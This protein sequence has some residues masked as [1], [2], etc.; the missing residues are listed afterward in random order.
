M[1]KLL[2]LLLTCITIGAAQARSLV[3]EESARLTNPDESY[4]DFG[5]GVAIDGDDAFVLLRRYTP[6]SD[7]FGTDEL[8]EIA[9]WLFRRVNGTWTPVRQLEAVRHGLEY[10]WGGDVAA[11]GGIA[12]L[13]INPLSIYERRNGDWVQVLD[14]VMSDEP[15]R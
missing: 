14:N 13:A 15:G 8:E 3:I 7:E 5:T 11:Q 1:K 10:I 9:V 6:P 4:P 12:A 2:L